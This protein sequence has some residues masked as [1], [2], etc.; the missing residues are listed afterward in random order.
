MDYSDIRTLGRFITR[1]EDQDLNALSELEDRFRNAEKKAQVIGITGPPGAGKSTLTNQI[2]RRLASYSKVA[3]IA[4]D[5]SSFISTGAL[6]GDRVRMQEHANNPNVFIRSMSNRN[7]L[8]GLS[9]ATPDIIK[10]F[11]CYGYDYVIVE[12]VGV[13]QDEIDIVKFSDTVTLV[14]HPASGDDMQAL[15]AGVMEIADIFV[16]NKCDFGNEAEKTYNIIDYWIG[17]NPREY[18]PPIIRTQAVTGD[19]VD[20][21]LRSFDQH[22]EYMTD[23]PDV[24]DF[25]RRIRAEHELTQKLYLLIED[26]INRSDG[27]IIREFSEKVMRD[28]IQPLAAAENILKGVFNE[29]RSYRDSSKEY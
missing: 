6:L 27:N 11:S 7:N 8:G 21:L 16:V 29:D 28:E 4:V 5:P 22:R 17:M 20:D 12:T 23:H 24:D 2:I 25:R 3:V 13:G 10:A 18:K 1:I 9:A 26:R 15:K 19:G 14:L